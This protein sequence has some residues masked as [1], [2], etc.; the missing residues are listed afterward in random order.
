MA[1]AESL[2]KAFAAGLV[3]AL[4]HSD[5]APAEKQARPKVAKVNDVEAAVRKYL[6]EKL[7]ES[8]PEQQDL[9]PPQTVDLGEQIAR[10]VEEARVAR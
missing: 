2:I 9:F 7:S 3:E 6:D 5:A 10:R 1:G 4:L 8:E